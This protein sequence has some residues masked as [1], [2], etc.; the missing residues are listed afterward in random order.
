MMWGGVRYWP[1]VCDLARAA[2]GVVYGTEIAYGVHPSC[3]VRSRLV[4]THHVVCGTEVAHGVQAHHVAAYPPRPPRRRGGLL[5]RPKSNAN[6]R[7]PRT[8]CTRTQGIAFD[9]T[10]APDTAERSDAAAV[11]RYALRFTCVTDAAL[12]RRC[13]SGRFKA[14]ST[15]TPR[16]SPSRARAPLASSP[17]H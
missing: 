12:C 5:L 9:F 10:A 13:L 14:L 11:V 4:C 6:A 3:G 16:P 7:F 15:R 8:V 17:T 1:R 2:H